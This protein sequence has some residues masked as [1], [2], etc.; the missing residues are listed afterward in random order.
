VLADSD[1][2]LA[3]FRTEIERLGREMNVDYVELRNAYPD[4]R[5]GFQHVSRY[6]TFTSD[7]SR[8]ETAILENIPR[9][10]RRMVRRSL[11]HGLESYEV[12]DLNGF[13]AL[14]HAS[15]RRLGTPSFPSA[16]FTNLSR[17]FGKSVSVREVRSGD[18]VIASVFV[19]YFRD[20]VLPYYGASDGDFHHLAP[21]NFMYFDL[22]RWAGASGYRIFDFG[23]SKKNVSGSYDFKSHW[24]MVERELPYEMLLVHRKEVPHI[25][26]ANPVFDLPRKIWGRMPLTLTKAVGPYVVRM[27]P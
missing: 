10:T 26:P 9:K 15:L 3:A 27:V 6:V 5:L 1:E 17:H 2:T 11:E 22:M 12:R 19:F 13:E 8:D 14:Y 16:H 7:I 20:Q 25:S 21:N 23:R 18:K 4:Q 24:G